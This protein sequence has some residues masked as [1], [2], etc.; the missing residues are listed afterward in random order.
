MAPTA[1]TVSRTLLMNNLLKK[2]SLGLVTIYFAGI[3]FIANSIGIAYD[4]GTSGSN[5]GA[6]S[7][8]V[9]HTAASGNNIAVAYVWNQQVTDTITG[10]TYNGSTMTKVD[11]ANTGTGT[12][13]SCFIL[14]NVD[15]GTNDNVVA[16]RSNSINA[17]N[18]VVVTYTGAAQTGQPDNHTTSSTA[19]ATSLAGTLITVADNSWLLMGGRWGHGGGVTAGAN[20]TLRVDSAGAD[21]YAFDS[22]GPI[23]P[24][25]SAT[26]NSS[27]SGTDGADACVISIAPVAAPAVTVGSFFWFF[28]W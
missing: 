4:T 6:S 5:N 20:T 12:Y 11:A 21:V 3:P 23:S 13:A 24:A 19:A 18:M 15:T 8:T 26:V 22:N 7:L 28:W 9:S 25:G 2:I 27:W 16:S 17:I 1:R 10:V 14:P